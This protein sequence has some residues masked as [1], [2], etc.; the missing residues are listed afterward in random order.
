M[1]DFIRRVPDGAVLTLESVMRNALSI[2]TMAIA[3]GLHVGCGIEDNLWDQ[4]GE[5]ISSGN[6]RIYDG[7][8]LAMGGEV[9]VVT[10][11]HRLAAF[12]YLNLAD[13]G[14][15]QDYAAAG[16]AGLLDLVLALEWVRDNISVFGG[17]PDRVTLLGQSGGGWK[18]SALLAMP[19]ARGLFQRAGVL[20][21]S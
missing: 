4:K 16:V 1:M 18:I 5:R 6:A 3:M 8:Q 19:K 13:L 10:I 17:D 15:G 12:G 21:G 14:G 11:T 9:V 7:T 2:S 20:S